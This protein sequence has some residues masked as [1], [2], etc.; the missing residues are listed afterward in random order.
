V[1]ALIARCYFTCFIAELVDISRADEHFDLRTYLFVG[2]AP[3]CSVLLPKA[4]LALKL[5][6]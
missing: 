5:S 4:R 6:E 3:C 1:G 2:R